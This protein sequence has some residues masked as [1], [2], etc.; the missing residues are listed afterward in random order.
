MDDWRNEEEYRHE[1][2]TRWDKCWL[3]VLGLITA[4]WVAFLIKAGGWVVY[5]I[6]GVLG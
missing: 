4:L 1:P 3:A 6:K 2:M 5:W